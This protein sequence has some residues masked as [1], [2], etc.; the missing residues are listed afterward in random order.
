M[1]KLQAI[2]FRVGY[3]IMK[4]WWFCTRPVTQ[5]VKCIVL[6][7]HNVLLIKHTYGSSLRTTVGG[8]IHKDEKPKAAVIREV[9]EE[10]GLTLNNIQ[11]IGE[12][13]HNGEFKKDTIHVFVAH[14]DDQKLTTDGAEIAEAQWY[15]QRAIPSDASP[16]FKQFYSLAKPHLNQK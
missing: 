13:Q 1:K 8:G 12:V 11:K 5:G 10:V 9:A 7:K 15:N 14:T 6:H 3:P 4:V 2:L 16:L